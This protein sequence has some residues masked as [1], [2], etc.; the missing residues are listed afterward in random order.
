MDPIELRF[1]NMQ[2]PGCETATGQ[3]L[4]DGIGLQE[5]LSCAVETA[6]MLGL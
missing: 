6:D 2:Y 3:L 1:R 4:N 5:C